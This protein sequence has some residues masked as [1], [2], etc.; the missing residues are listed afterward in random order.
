MF[1]VRK[2]DVSNIHRRWSFTKLNPSSSKQSFAISIASGAI[3]VIVSYVFHLSTTIG[4]LAFY[5][6][7]GLG[8]L[9]G[10][11]MLD[12][13]ALRGTP[14]NKLSKIAHVSAFANSLWALTVCLGVAADLVFS[15]HGGGNYVMAGMLL[16]VSLRIGIFAS[17]FGATIGRA[18]I[19]SFIQPLVFLL[20]FLNPSNYSIILSPIGLGF[21][22]AFVLL[23]TTWEII[24]DRAGRPSIKSTFKILQAFLAAWTENKVDKM[25]EFLEER[26]HDEVIST[27]ILNF[28]LNRDSKYHQAVIVLPDVHPGPFGMVG[29]SNL[30]Y[31][32]HE[33][34]SKTA[35]IMHSVSDHSMNIPSKY[36]V[37][38][39]LK[40][41]AKAKVTE[42]GSL[43][44][45]PVQV[46]MNNASTTGIAFGST[47]LVMLSLA[48]VGM[49]DVSS[50][51]RKDLE[52]HG[53][54]LGFSNVLIIDC[55]N[56]MGKHLNDSDKADLTIC[57]KQCLDQL[58]N[59]TP[60]QEFTVGFA[61]LSD[62][63]HNL[64]Q[65][66]ELGQAGLAAIVIGIAGR[67]YAIGW[68]D[69]NNME[70]KLRDY[71]VSKMDSGVKVLEVCTSDTHSTSGKRTREGYFAL[72]SSST[73]ED[74]AQA[75]LRMCK[76]ASEHMVKSTF[77]FHV[78]QSTIKVMG[79]KQFKDYSN[80]L[81]KSM[82]ITKIFLGVTI[83]MFNAMLILS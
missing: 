20:A 78:S 30:P 69:S 22:F 2:D 55:H 32:L 74:I 56:A 33:A 71:I 83:A 15:K 38:R 21:G 7:F 5:L 9:A 17:V 35:L 61:Q 62:I 70:N 45:I 31:I 58:K 14:V 42:R 79:N 80:A 1:A 43:C 18:I 11:H 23:G 40:D 82:K 39:Y 53:T 63:S 67:K 65:A 51:V 44:S 28:I 54:N 52:S 60:Q 72:G 59:Q 41:L 66:S 10:A 6:P 8:M 77:E 75:Y 57:A 34:F 46:K 3:V 49:E 73:Y 64:R 24:A 76:E 36:E 16:A 37:E 26:A 47:V 48:P 50:S 13:L 29:G 68:A 81:D 12:Y 25:E 4:T 19:V 27:K